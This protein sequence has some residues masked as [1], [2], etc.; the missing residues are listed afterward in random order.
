[1]TYEAL[2]MCRDDD[3]FGT[4]DDLDTWFDGSVDRKLEA[5]TVAALGRA[6]ATNRIDEFLLP[7]TAIR[8]VLLLAGVD[9]T[10]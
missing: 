10:R 5:S 7:P 6:E 4:L 1:M 3:L 8:L 2:F 9:V